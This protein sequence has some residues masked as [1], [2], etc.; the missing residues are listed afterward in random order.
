MYLF[1][2]DIYRRNYVKKI[3]NLNLIT[4]L[5]LGIKTSVSEKRYKYSSG[6][7]NLNTVR[8]G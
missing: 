3:I 1:T 4:F 5:S 7:P 2:V 6:H 8:G